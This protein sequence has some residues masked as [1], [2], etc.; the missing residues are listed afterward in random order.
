MNIQINNERR[1]PNLEDHI[2]SRLTSAFGRYSKRIDRIEVH[3][4][5][6]SPGNDGAE[7]A[8]TIDMKLTPRGQ[9]HV[10]GKDKN[11]Y[12]AVADAT[13]RAERSFLKTASRRRARRHTQPTPLL[14]DTPNIGERSLT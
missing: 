7:K 10:G 8:C 12:A 9:I 1:N 14:D 11:I 6:E 3:V 2:R 13:R 5:D 4:R